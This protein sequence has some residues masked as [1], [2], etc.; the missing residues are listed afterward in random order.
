MVQKDF[1]Q[2]T[3]VKKMLE[4]LNWK[5]E[6]VRC[7]IVR[8]IDGLAMSSRNVRLNLEERQQALT[9]S[10]VLFHLKKENF[11]S[12]KDFCQWAISELKKQSLIKVEYVEMVDATT[13]QPV[14]NWKDTTELVCCIA[15]KV[16]EVRLIDNVL[17]V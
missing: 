8:E 14:K 16:G 17:I 12:P 5:T 10:Q 6:L 1:Q 13:L 15:A 9:I 11:S 4:L 7:D 3:I 2:Q